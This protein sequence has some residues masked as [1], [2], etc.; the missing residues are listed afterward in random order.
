MWSEG[1]AE[2]GGVSQILF[3]RILKNGKNTECM[4]KRGNEAM[5]RGTVPASMFGALALEV[6]DRGVR[7]DIFRI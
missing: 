1:L 6:Q 4:T 7:E 5:S 3:A 2:L